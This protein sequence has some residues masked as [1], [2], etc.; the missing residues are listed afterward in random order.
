M[1]GI[2]PGRRASY[3]ASTDVLLIFFA[4]WLSYALRFRVV[5]TWLLSRI[6]EDWTG[7]S[8][9]LISLYLLAFYVFELYSLA[10]N[11][12]SVTGILRC[13]G[14]VAIA[15]VSVALASFALPRWGVGRGLLALHAGIL[16][17]F[18]VVSRTSSSRAMQSRAPADK[19]LLLVAGPIS[20]AVMSE[21]THNPQSRY[22]IV[23]TI[24][25]RP[26]TPPPGG[27][28]GSEIPPPV[29]KLSDA[30]RFLDEHGVRHVLVA[31]IDRLTPDATRELLR[32]KTH[33]TEVHDLFAAFQILSGRLPVEDLTDAYFLRVQ[34]FTRDTRPVLSNL[35]RV[36][37]VL[38]SVGLLVASAP[39]M[40]LAV[41]GIKLTM[42][43]TVIYSQER[44]GK[45]DVP[46]VMHKFRSMGLDAESSGP[47][48]AKEKDPRVTPFGKFLRRTRIDELPQLWNVLR[49]DMSLVGP[50]PERR[51]FVDTLKEQIPY[52]GLRSQIKPGL[53]GWAQVNYRYGSSVADTRVK[54]SY[55]LYYIQERSVALFSLT[56]LKTVQTVL[57]KPGS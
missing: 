30:E 28:L 37:D 14:A 32:L 2:Y 19:A 25:L 11:F 55:D 8:A 21:I 45:D 22:D 7:A 31:G 26:S 15:A 51:V 17:V 13:V 5:G 27:S 42:P 34:S 41:V 16:A 24:P 9:L 49:G 29:G 36:L 48:W 50:R 57:F 40:A 33:G 35:F 6:L 20:E 46:Y 12:R 3:L 4:L 44:V 53:T 54:L 23:R 38:V 39:V 10:L 43:G 47:Q 18:T 1:S 52:Y 56:L